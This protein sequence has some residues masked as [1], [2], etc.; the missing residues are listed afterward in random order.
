MA[1]YFPFMF[2]PLKFTR[3]AGHQKDDCVAEK[4]KRLFMP[5]YERMTSEFFGYSLS[6]FSPIK[7]NYSVTQYRVCFLHHFY[8]HSVSTADKCC[9]PLFCC[10]LLKVRLEQLKIGK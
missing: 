3:W 9:V 8:Q 2:W 6:S 1:P 5:V 10:L 7:Q 4:N